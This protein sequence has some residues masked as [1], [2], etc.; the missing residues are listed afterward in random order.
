MQHRHIGSTQRKHL[1][2]AVARRRRVADRFVIER[3]PQPSERAKAKAAAAATYL[4]Q[5]ELD[6]LNGL[7]NGAV[8][9]AHYRKLMAKAKP[10]APQQ[11]RKKLPREADTYRGVRGNSERGPQRSLILKAERIANAETRAQADR[12]RALAASA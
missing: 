7:E 8:C 10:A 4:S 1:A 5:V 9:R 11:T 12:R 3:S 2:T 6:K